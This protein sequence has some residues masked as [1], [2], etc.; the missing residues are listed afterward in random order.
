M[1]WLPLGVDGNRRRHRV[2]YELKMDRSV[3]IQLKMIG[4]T[5]VTYIF[6]V[7]FLANLTGLAG[8]FYLV[9]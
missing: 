3:F 9:A 5:N 4:T 7:D 2:L 1:T 8:G 6:L